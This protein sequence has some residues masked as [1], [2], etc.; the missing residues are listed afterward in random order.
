MVKT[1]TDRPEARR[2]RSDRLVALAV[3]D[4]IEPSLKFISTRR[5]ESGGPGPDGF[6]LK[7]ESL[8]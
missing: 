1:A 6:A 7:V 2:L 3:S 5:R 8:Y 4:R